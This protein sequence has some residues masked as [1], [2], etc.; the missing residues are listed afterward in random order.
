M[1]DDRV[2]RDVVLVCDFLVEQALGHADKNL[3]F[4]LGE[5][6]LLRLL[7]PRTALEAPGM[8]DVA[9]HG[10]QDL[11]LHQGVAGQ[12]ALQIVQKAEHLA[13]EGVVGSVRQGLHHQVL[14]VTQFLVDIAVVLREAGDGEAPG[15]AAEDQVLDVGDHFVFLKGEMLFELL[16]VPVEEAPDHLLL[17]LAERRN[18]L[19]DGLFKP[20]QPFV[21]VTLVRLPYV[22]H[23]I[24][25]TASGQEFRIRLVILEGVDIAD[26]AGRV[27]V[28]AAAGRGLFERTLP[29]AQAYAQPGQDIHEVGVPVQDVSQLGLGREDGVLGDHICKGMQ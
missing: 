24:G 26:Q 7:F 28:Q 23:D 6:L 14:E 3:L 13:P 11:V 22:F 25:D 20:N 27:R 15:V 5:F 8:L 18:Q 12:V 9:R 2:D 1:G 21:E 4:P 16:L 29:E 10:R 17:L 19:S